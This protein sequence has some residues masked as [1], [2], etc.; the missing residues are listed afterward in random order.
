[1]PNPPSLPTQRV[2]EQAS[3]R[4]DSKGVSFG[5]SRLELSDGALFVIQLSRSRAPVV[6]GFQEKSVDGKSENLSR[7]EKLSDQ[8]SQAE[9][10]AGQ[11]EPQPAPAEQ[12]ERRTFWERVFRM[13]PLRKRIEKAL[14]E[15]WKFTEVKP[16]HIEE[17]LSEDSEEMRA[18]FLSGA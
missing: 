15:D 3:Y 18:F 9:S 17:L 2:I 7:Q 5:D 8:E 11:N 16:R 13:P 4:A 14:N 10:K 1:M 6:G 12:P